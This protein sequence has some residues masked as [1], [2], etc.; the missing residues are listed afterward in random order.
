MTSSNSLQTSLLDAISSAEA[1]PASRTPKPDSAEETT[2]LDTSGHI[3]VESLMR[4]DQLGWSAKMFA[5]CLVGTMDVCTR[6]CSMT[7]RLSAT[8]WGRMFCQ[9]SPKVH[10][11]AGTASGLLQTATPYERLEDPSEMRARA[12]AAGYDN[13]TRFNTLLSQVVYSQ[14]SRDNF[15]G[16]LPTP[17]TQ[18][19]R[20]GENNVEGAKHRWER[21]STAVADYAL[22]LIPTPTAQQNR[23]NPA[24][25]RGKGN[26]SDAVAQRE[27]VS[28]TGFHLSPLFVEEMMGFPRGWTA[29]PFQSGEE[30]P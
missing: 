23:A 15:P 20:I 6:R 30:S 10:H 9:L 18:D 26:L 29:S 4:F 1:F 21:G 2:T 5:A 12:E 8:K 28:G 19:A 25:D 27:R 22:G 24:V 11:I 16:L 17:L 14:E 7:F 3:C 13:R